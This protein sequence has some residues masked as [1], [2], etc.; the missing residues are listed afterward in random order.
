[1]VG[2]YHV[3]RIVKNPTYHY[4]PVKNEAIVQAILDGAKPIDRATREADYRAGG[5]S[6]FDENAD[7]YVRD[8][9][10]TGRLPPSS[11]I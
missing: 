6:R 10:A 2:E 11:V 4:D 9:T 8:A 1:M 5:W 7:P 3:V